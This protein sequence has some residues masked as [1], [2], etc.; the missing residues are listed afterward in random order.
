M[1]LLTVLDDLPYWVEGLEGKPHLIVP[2]TLDIND[3]RFATPR[4]F[5]SAIKKI[6]L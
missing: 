6:M 1:F 4:G 2:Y 3:M 5:S